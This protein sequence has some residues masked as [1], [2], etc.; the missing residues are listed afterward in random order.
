MKALGYWI[1]YISAHTF[2]R[3]STRVGVHAVVVVCDTQHNFLGESMMQG[4]L[5]K[6]G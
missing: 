3:I 6:Q 5:S 1:S 2:L 4:W